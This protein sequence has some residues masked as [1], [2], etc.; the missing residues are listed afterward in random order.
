VNGITREVVVKVLIG[1]RKTPLYPRREKYAKKN[2]LQFFKHV[3]DDKSAET[4]VYANVKEQKSE[5]SSL[6]LHDRIRADHFTRQ[7]SDITTR[8]ATSD[9]NNSNVTTNCRSSIIERVCQ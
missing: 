5:K 6:G 4:V 7:G 9:K 8:N 1:Y 3:D 2:F